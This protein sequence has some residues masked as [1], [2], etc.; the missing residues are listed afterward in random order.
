MSVYLE[1]FLNVPKQPVPQASGVKPPVEAVLAEFDRQQRDDETAQLVTDLLAADRQ[2][3]VIEALGHALLREDA[4]FHS[5]Q[6]YEAALRQY[7]NF[8]GR[9]EEII[10]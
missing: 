10:S 1:R 7:Q 2:T 4:G 9:P 3:E 8:A 6:I 5:F